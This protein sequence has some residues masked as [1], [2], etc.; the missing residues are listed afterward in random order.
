LADDGETGVI[1]QTGE[2]LAQQHIVIGEHDPG[3]DRALRRCL[4][5]PGRWRHR[6]II[7]HPN[8]PCR[9]NHDQRRPD[10]IRV[11]KRLPVPPGPGASAQLRLY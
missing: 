6:P 9:G 5:N 8:G 7:D 2:A 10:T 4:G 3:Y 11:R 1:Q